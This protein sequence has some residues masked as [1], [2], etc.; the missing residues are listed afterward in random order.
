VPRKYPPV[1]PGT[2]PRPPQGPP[3]YPWGA[4][5][6]PGVPPH[7]PVVPPCAPLVPPEENRGFSWGPPPASAPEVPPRP[8]WT[9]GST[10]KST[11]NNFCCRTKT[12]K[13]YCLSQWAFR[14]ELESGNSRNPL[15][16]ISSFRGGSFTDPFTQTPFVHPLPRP[17]RPVLH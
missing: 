3:G 17:P 2:P 16:L 5:Y 15:G 11:E 14:G 7:T 12:L 8:G 9:S 1:T 13:T 4:G 10:H 6:P